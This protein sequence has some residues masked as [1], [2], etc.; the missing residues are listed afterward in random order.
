MGDENMEKI[1]LV[2]GNNLIFRSYY[3]TAATGNLMVNSKNYPTN[4]LYGF[5]NMINKIIEEEKPTYMVVAYDIGKNFRHE[6]YKEYKAGR[7][8]TPNELI[9]QLNKSK[10]LLDAMGIK[11]IELSNYEADDIIGTLSKMALDDKDF[12]ATI[13][14]SDKDLLQLINDEVEVKLLKSKDYIRYTKEKFIEDYGIEPIR[15]IDLKALM[16]DSSDNVPGV[17]GIGEKTALKLLQQYNT[18]EEIYD[19]IDSIKGATHDKLLKDITSAYF[20]KD[21]CTICLNAP[22]KESL[23]DCKYLGPDNNKLI[24]I[25][26]ELEFYSY[27]KKMNFKQED[28]KS[29]YKILE[30][31]N[32]INKNN[33]IS[34]YIECDNEN[35]HDAKIL[36]MGIYDGNNLFYV[37]P[38]MINECLEYLKNTEKYTYDL[39]K[40]INLLNNINLNTSFDLMIAA[41]LLNYQIKEDLGILMNKEGIYVPFYSEVIKNKSNIENEITLKAKYIFDNK[42]RFINELEK[43]E[44]LSLFNDIEMPLVTILA[45]MELNGIICDKNI[46]S[47]LQKD[48]NKNLDDIAKQIYEVCGE[49]FNINSP[50]QL[51]IVLFEHMKLPCTHKK[52]KTNRYNTDASTI[53]KL[54]KTIPELKLIIEYRNLAKLN[55]TYLDG[56]KDYIREDGKIHTIYKQALTRTGR[57]SSLDP[58]MQN[59]PSKK[60][61][62]KLVKK[63]F[64]PEYDLFLST[65]YSQIE[66]RVLAHLSGSKELINAFNN[67]ID[68]HKQVASDIFGVPLEEVTTLQRGKAKAVVFG[69]V[70]GISSF[71]LSEN[72]Q[73]TPTEAKHLIEKF[74]ELYPGV[75]EYMDKTVK[76]AYEN[77]YVRTLFNRKRYVEEL[78]NKSYLIRQSGERIAMNTPIQG[79][80]ADILKIAMIKIDKEI[81]K[82]KLKSKMLL[83]V[84]DELI[85]DCL[86]SEK[87]ILTKIVKDAMENTVKLDVDLKASLD[88]GSTWFDTK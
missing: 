70:Y 55:S 49:E 50:I 5:N 33:K 60:E 61:D 37:K 3:A 19:N 73:I 86:D 32:E 80:S 41:Y 26:K 62:G 22:I 59:I 24:E 48:M 75:K 43:E 79:T 4:A 6:K 27:L 51:G 25:Y 76:D 8:A 66:L 11:H 87:E 63:A 71:G 40:N 45:K 13:I 7:S 52:N 34:Y 58:N 20:C 74:N 18:I 9:I 2:D 64:L 65:D 46:L 12:V 88:F 77:G 47:S 29:A 78:T 42:D 81:T 83:Q 69:I 39:K 15:M 23:K 44:M 30:N 28:T 54:S 31:L 72:L 1:I 16:G 57:L 14:S 35:Y 38:E 85:F 67:N 84:H 36:G 10:E 53:L 21:I 56:L 68:I 82:N 17:K